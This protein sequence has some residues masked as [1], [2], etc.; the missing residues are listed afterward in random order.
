MTH[1][2]KLLFVYLNIL[3]FVY[4]VIN[5]R[6]KNKKRKVCRCGAG[7]EE[8]PSKCDT[9]GFPI[10]MEPTLVCDLRGFDRLELPRNDRR[11]VASLRWLLQ[12]WRANCDI[13]VLLYECGL[14]H[15]NS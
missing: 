3:L 12:G 1:I 11:I 15:P 4:I 10:R 8:T 14:L 2:I 9:P 13:Q 7:V 5:Q 6:T